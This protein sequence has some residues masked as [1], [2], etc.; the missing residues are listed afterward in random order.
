MTGLATALQEFSTRSFRFMSDVDK[1][2]LWLQGAL[3][4]AGIYVSITISLIGYCVLQLNHLTQRLISIESASFTS[5]DADKLR[6]SIQSLNVKLATESAPKWLTD[7]V[8]R[9]QSQ[10]ETLERERRKF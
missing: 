1:T 3:W 10:V 5:R 6:D 7:Q 2:K 9:L 8:T 4:A